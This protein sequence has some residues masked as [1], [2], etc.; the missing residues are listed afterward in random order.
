VTIAEDVN[1]KGMPSDELDSELSTSFVKDPQLCQ[2]VLTDK[3][4]NLRFL[5]CHQLCS[6]MVGNFFKTKLGGQF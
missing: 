1:V 5:F 2:P 4:E 3:V 6:D